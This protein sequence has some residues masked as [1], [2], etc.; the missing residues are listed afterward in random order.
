MN[1]LSIIFIWFFRGFITVTER[2]WIEWEKEGVSREP[3][4]K[5]E[6]RGDRKGS[7]RRDGE[8]VWGRDTER[9]NHMWI[10]GKNIL[11]R[12]TSK[13]QRPK[14]S[15]QFCDSKLL[16]FWSS[17]LSEWWYHNYDGEDLER[18]RFKR[19]RNRDLEINTW[20]SKSSQFL[21]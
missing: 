19:K 13:I 8:T 11:R 4:E 16:W 9:M 17:H 18:C 14:G 15:N 2:R 10:W 21:I 3:G 5:E 7:G 12:G 1:L 20:T 6:K